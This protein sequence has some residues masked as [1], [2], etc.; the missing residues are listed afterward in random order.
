MKVLIADDSESLRQI[1][2]FTLTENGHEVTAAPDGKAALEK[3]SADYKL[4]ITDLNMPV[5]NGIELIKA[6]RAGNVNKFVPII[7][8]TTESEE[9]K[10]NEAKQAGAT[11]WITKP[12][13]PEILMETIGKVIA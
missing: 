12:F 7:M 5:M 11:A 4:V 6:I 10:R 9:Q 3:F 8:L 2:E 1:V 13:T